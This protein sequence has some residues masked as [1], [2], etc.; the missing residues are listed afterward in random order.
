[1]EIP[2]SVE[3]PGFRTNLYP[4]TGAFLSLVSPFAPIPARLNCLNR[5]NL[6]W[7]KTPAAPPA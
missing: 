5:L 7:I 6:S 2:Y 4:E 1:M 3:W